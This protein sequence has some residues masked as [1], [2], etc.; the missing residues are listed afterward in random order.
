[1]PDDGTGRCDSVHPSTFSVYECNNLFD[2]PTFESAD[3]LASGDFKAFWYSNNNGATDAHFAQFTF[4]SP[5]RVASY[6]IA[7][8]H[9]SYLCGTSTSSRQCFNAWRLSGKNADDAT[10]TTLDTVSNFLFSHNGEIYP[11]EFTASHFAPKSLGA[12]CP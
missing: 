10:F 3:K 2:G 8:P 1:M 7:A 6:A 12:A 9:T 4:N 5:S 11:P